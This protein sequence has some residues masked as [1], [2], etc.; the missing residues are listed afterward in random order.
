MAYAFRLFALIFAFALVGCGDDT[1]SEG[2]GTGGISGTG[3]TAGSG[4]SG[5]VTGTG[6]MAGAG[7]VGGIGGTA[8]VGGSSTTVEPCTDDGMCGVEDDCVCPECDDD[9]FCGDADN[10]E[11]DGV[12][13]EFEEGCICEDCADLPVCER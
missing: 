7:G 5:G 4:A 13:A 2:P 12:C 6:G 3:G 11:N 8:G 1:P 9:L 10:C